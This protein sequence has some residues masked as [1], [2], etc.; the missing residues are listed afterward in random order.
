[1]EYTEKLINAS[2]ASTVPY[3]QWIWNNNYQMN[4]TC[5]LQQ[6]TILKKDLFTKV[7]VKEWSVYTLDV[8]NYYLFSQTNV[9]QK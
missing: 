1:M 7:D 9:E 5:W 8:I 2:N 6:Y 4:N 3:L